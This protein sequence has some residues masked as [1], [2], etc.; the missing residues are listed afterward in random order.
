PL[1]TFQSRF[2]HAPFRAVD[3]NRHAR[4]F[5]F[6]ANE[7]YEACHG[8]FG[9]EHS[10]VEIDVDDVG[11]IRDLLPRNG[12]GPI[13]IARQDC[14]RKLWRTSAVA[15]LADDDESKL[16]RDVERF[17]SG[18]G[19]WNCGVRIADCGLIRSL[20]TVCRKAARWKLA[21]LFG[22]CR[23]VRRGGSATATD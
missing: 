18:E 22:K 11:P 3:H 15:A 20:A 13:E 14:F 7:I 10:F 12:H 5:R 16:W 21:R 6:A 17:Q 9:I 4:D 23:D 2:D 1:G 8:S 19:E